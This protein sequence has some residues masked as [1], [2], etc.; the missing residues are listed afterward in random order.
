MCGICG[1]LEIRGTPADAS[2]LEKMS[3][4]LVHRGPDSGGVFIDGFTG[5]AARRL[6]IIDLIGGD[7]PIANEDGS[8]H[9]VQNGEIYN[10]RELRRE[11]ASQGHVFRTESDTEVLVHQYEQHGLDFAN[12]LRGM[13]SIAIWDSRRRRLVLARDRYGIKPLYYRLTDERFEFASELK[14]LERTR[15]VA[16]TLDMRA[17]EAFLAFNV[18]P[19]PLT[20]YTDTSK[21]EA[22]HVLV[23]DADSPRAP[24]TSAAR[25][26]TRSLQSC[27][28]AYVTPFART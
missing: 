7:Q 24:P 4:M 25:A 19:A 9:V 22:G 6:A 26:T 5:L 10:Y 17:V 18:V 16:P 27:S 15:D 13:F 23:W 11:L 1:S 8:V 12:A 3:E 20:I 14:A 2:R 21:L 28:N